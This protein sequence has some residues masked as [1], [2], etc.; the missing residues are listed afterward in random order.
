VFIWI[1]DCC[2]QVRAVVIIELKA[3]KRIERNL[4]MNIFYLQIFMLAGIGIAPID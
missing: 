3:I 2:N 1:A 4:R